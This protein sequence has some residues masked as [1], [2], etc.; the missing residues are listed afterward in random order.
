MIA[1]ACTLLLA[2]LPLAPQDE[3]ETA[4]PSPTAARPGPAKGLELIYLGGEGLLLR[5]R[6]KTVVVDS[7]L[8]H[9][10]SL[11]PIPTEVLGAMMAG[12]G[13]FKK[14]HLCIGT[15]LHGEGYRWESAAEFLRHQKAAPGLP[16][17]FDAPPDLGIELRK[18]LGDD[19][20][21][22]Q[23]NDRW[24]E[25]GA[26]NKSFLPGLRVDY[27]NL[28]HVG[29]GEKLP[30]HLG[31]AIRH[32]GLNVV[33]FAHA[34][35]RAEDFEPYQA[36]IANADVAIVP[37]TYLLDEASRRML[38]DRVAPRHVV[39]T[40]IPAEGASE[41]AAAL[42]KLYPGVIALTTPMESHVF[43]PAPPK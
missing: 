17:V 38:Q 32:A 40:G 9:D 27:L 4:P 18:Y 15:H 41:T 36:L 13:I 12:E 43:E 3:A 19:Y 35:P 33:F 23:I 37:H 31:L 26:E 1:A 16:T 24:Q 10:P 30:R 2:L 20:P 42:E 8:T 39:A 5:S 28:P 6:A 29:E 21:G 34:A 25:V 22:S 14:V 7:F 11:V